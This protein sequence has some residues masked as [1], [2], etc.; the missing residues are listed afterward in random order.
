MRIDAKFLVYAAILVAVL[1]KGA[2][3]LAPYENL[4]AKGCTL[5]YVYDGD[6]VALDC[7]SEQITAR[8]LGFDTP[9]AK[10]PQCP[11]EKALADQATQR[12]R[13]LSRS[14]ALTFAG[15]ELDRYGR[16]LVTM[17]VDGQDV[18][19]ILIGE[20]LAVPYAGGRRIDWCARLAS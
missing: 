13:A 14:G 15:Q 8:L 18:G 16:T 4:T 19:P 5:D 9:E 3:W 11:A 17:K 10:S 12:L 7:G 1:I 20:D 6:T 2:D